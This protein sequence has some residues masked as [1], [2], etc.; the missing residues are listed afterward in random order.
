MSLQVGQRDEKHRVFLGWKVRVLAATTEY[1]AAW[2][3][4]ALKT[5]WNDLSIALAVID[6]E[7]QRLELAGAKSHARLV[8]VYRRESKMRR[9]LRELVEALAPLST[10]HLLLGDVVDCAEA[11][12]KVL[13]GESASPPACNR[14]G[15][16]ILGPHEHRIDGPA[17]KENGDG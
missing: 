7:N 3:T 9:A 10:N 8:R 2:Q 17:A 11:A 16:K 14:V 1:A 12:R 13:N 6:Q 15:C 5:T 4:A